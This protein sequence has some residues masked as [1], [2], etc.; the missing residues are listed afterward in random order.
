MTGDSRR[1]AKRETIFAP[2]EADGDLPK[3]ISGA[4]ILY[5]LFEDGRRQVLDLAGPGDFL[6][7]DLE[8]AVDHYA[9]ALMPSEV[10]YIPGPALLQDTDGAAFMVEQMRDRLAIERRHLTLLSYKSAMDRLEAFVKLAADC[11]GHDGARVD[12]PLTRQQIADFTGLTLETV[13]RTF[14]QWERDAVLTKIEGQ[15]YL[16]GAALAA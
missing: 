1:F 7:F 9:E 4:V 11:L 16:M 13:S 2:G 12:L 8:G 10:A 14:A 15:T 6:H 3:L 5:T